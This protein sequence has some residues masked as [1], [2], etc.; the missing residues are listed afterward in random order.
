V[1]TIDQPSGENYYNISVKLAVDFRA[2]SYVDVV[3][4]LKKEEVKELESRISR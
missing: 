3:D 1:H 4:N 2:L